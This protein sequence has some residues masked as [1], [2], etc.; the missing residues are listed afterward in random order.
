MLTLTVAI[1][2]VGLTLLSACPLAQPRPCMTDADCND[3]NACT[4]DTCGGNGVCV[5]DPVDCD[6]GDAC[7]TD[8]C[9]ARSGDC[10]HDPV[11]C[12]AGQTCRVEPG[13]CVPTGPTELSH[14]AAATCLGCHGATAITGVDV[15]S[16]SNGG[17]PCKLNKVEG[18]RMPTYPFSGIDGTLAMVGDNDEPLGDGTLDPNV[19]A[20]D[21]TLGTPQSYNDVSYVIGGYGRKSRWI[22][23][24][25][26]V[27]RGSATQYNLETQGL[28]A[29]PNNQ[30]DRPHSCGKRHTAGY[31]A[32]TKNH[33]GIKGLVEN[34][35]FPGIQCQE[36]HGAGADHVAG[37]PVNIIAEP[38]ADTVCKE[39]HTRYP[40]DVAAAG[41]SSEATSGGTSSA[42]ADTP[43]SCLTD[44]RPGQ[45]TTRRVS[46]TV[47]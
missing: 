12:P 42:V 4:V 6:D 1:C 15:S 46:T 31:N 21:N 24:D 3:G 39:C 10:V 45:Q 7:T 47:G 32:D 11:D 33:L 43:R 27:V 28:P 38:D 2:G 25:G 23:S 36:C 37:P 26:Y 8:S 22:D 18:G 9:D 30:A 19:G 35:A 5:N 34:W 13:Q 16:V 17:H 29:Y 14:V 40:D 44:A 20:T 41:G